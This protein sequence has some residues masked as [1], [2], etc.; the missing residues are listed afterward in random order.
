[1]TINDLKEWIES[2]INDLGLPYKYNYNVGRFVEDQNNPENVIIAIKKGAGSVRPPF[3]RY[4]IYQVLIISAQYF[5]SAIDENGDDE[6]YSEDD[7]LINFGVSKPDKKMIKTP[8]N[9]WEDGE[10][11]ADAIEIA[12]DKEKPPCNASG[13]TLLSSKAGPLYLDDGR[14]YYTLDLEVII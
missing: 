5:M 11:I 3:I 14:I 7:P 4:N 9:I 1:M 10:L 13:I 8:V 12:S 6:D 2:H